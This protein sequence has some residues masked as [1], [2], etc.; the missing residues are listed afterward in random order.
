MEPVAAQSSSSNGPPVGQGHAVAR[1]LLR[2]RPSD[3]AGWALDQAALLSDPAVN[4][5]QLPIFQLA[6]VLVELPP[7]TKQALVQNAVAGL[8][9]L[10]PS[11][12]VEAV[13]LA[14]QTANIVQQAESLDVEQRMHQEHAAALQR[15]A[16][17]QQSAAGANSQV[18]AAPSAPP[19]IKNFLRVVEEAKLNQ[20]PRE[21][22]ALLV[23][24]AQSHAVQLAQ[25]QQLLDVVQELRPEER[26]QLTEVLVEAHVV[27]E[28]QRFLLEEAVRPGGYA[29]AL[30]GA[31]K[32]MDYAKEFAWVIGAVPAV[33]FGLG[34]ILGALPC[35]SGMDGWLRTDGFLNL[36]L[37]G[38]VFCAS[39]ILE[40][41]LEGIK[42]DPLAAV[43]RW[44]DCQEQDF[45]S[46]LEV[47][48]PGVPLSTYQHAAGGLLV[49]LVSM[50][51]G[52]LWAVVGVFQ[53]LDGL[54][55]GCTGFT[56]LCAFAYIGLRAGLVLGALWLLYYVLDEI[57][58]LRNR[59]PMTA[60]SQL[61]MAEPAHMNGSQKVVVWEPVQGGHGFVME[62]QGRTR[63]GPGNV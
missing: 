5:E 51:L 44:Q 34:F 46:H 43:R 14:M 20:V 10:P 56:M 26:A 53:F 41:A 35:G 52:V 29:D 18:D 23:K 48:V 54:I 30:S 50:V 40:P 3:L 36:I 16:N 61:P 22:R 11:R 62:P 12:K 24:E 57:Q 17:A 21:E 33:E 7:V 39:Q 42:Q 8:A 27:S 60:D 32:W 49:A 15:L 45:S 19:L 2:K 25:P 55:V 13:R 1:E 31:L 38:A 47:L 37:A 9:E 63:P 28:E 6:H 4:V 58:R 59:M